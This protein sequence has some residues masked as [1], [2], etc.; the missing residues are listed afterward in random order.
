MDKVAVE[1]RGEG[2]LRAPIAVEAA[3]DAAEARRDLLPVEG[4]EVLEHGLAHGRGVLA[5]PRVILRPREGAHALE[6][7]AGRG[8]EP[9]RGAGAVDDEDAEGKGEVAGGGREGGRRGRGKG[10]E[11]AHLEDA[12]AVGAVGGLR[13]LDDAHDAA[14]GEPHVGGPVGGGGRRDREGRGVTA[15]RVR[16]RGARFGG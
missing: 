12:D 1:D 6:V 11:G 9:R 2:L 3:P 5:E 14:R 7:F 4:P 16:G 13:V 15:S 10:G 8:R